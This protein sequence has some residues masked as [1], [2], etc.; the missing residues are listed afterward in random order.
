M[1]ILKVD[2]LGIAVKSLDEAIKFYRDI[3]GLELI[4]IEEVPQEK[5]KVAIFKVGETYIELLQATA[6]DSAIAKFIEKR[7]EGLHHIALRV[8]NIAK[9]IKELKEKGIEI[10]YEQPR[11][12]A[13]G[14]RIINFIHPKSAYGVLLEIVER[15]G[16]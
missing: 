8:N 9:A 6:P 15:K 4:K 11:E 3:L 1:K 10:V 5:V 14:K 7:G 12:V 16:E 2:H 13:H